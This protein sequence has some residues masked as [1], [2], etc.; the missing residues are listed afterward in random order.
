LFFTKIMRP[1][2]FFY[3]EMGEEGTEETD[4]VNGLYSK[5]LEERNKL[6]EDIIKRLDKFN[7]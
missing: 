6:L 7:E 5:L 3:L 1:R 2:S 4:V